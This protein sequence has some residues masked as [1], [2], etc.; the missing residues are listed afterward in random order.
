MCTEPL[1]TGTSMTLRACPVARRPARFATPAWRPK[2]RPTPDTGPARQRR[3]A[4]PESGNKGEPPSSQ[5]PAGFTRSQPEQ[6]K[7]PV[8]PSW[9]IQY[10]VDSFALLRLVRAPE[11]TISIIFLCRAHQHPLVPARSCLTLTPST[12]T[13]PCS[14]LDLSW[15]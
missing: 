6:S 15:L 13:E 8:L 14:C 10:P 9:S 5:W 4:P 1:P 12:K 7:H 3:R 2:G 11:L